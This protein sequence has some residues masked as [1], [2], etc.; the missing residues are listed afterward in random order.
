[1]RGSGPRAGHAAGAPSTRLAAVLGLLL[2]CLSLPGCGY[3]LAGRGSFLPEYI[4]TIGVPVTFMF[5][6]FIIVMTTT[7]QLLN[8]VLDLTRI[9]AAGFSP[10]DW[11]DVVPTLL[12]AE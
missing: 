5:V 10:P 3:S 8:S 6:L 1:M 9:K 12:G 2:A 11:R 7:P 4:R